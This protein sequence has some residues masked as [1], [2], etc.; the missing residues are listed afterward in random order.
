MLYCL[1]FHNFIKWVAPDVYRT[2]C[3]PSSLIFSIILF[4]DG[5]Q[6][7][8]ARQIISV[9]LLRTPRFSPTVLNLRPIIFVP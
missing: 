2:F 3:S 9:T 5:F 1:E 8:V 7:I 4:K 6:N